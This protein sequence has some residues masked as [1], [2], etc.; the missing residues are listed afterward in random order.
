MIINK[1]NYSKEALAV[2]LCIAAICYTIATPIIII[3]LLLSFAAFTYYQFEKYKAENISQK[4]ATAA[5]LIGTSLLFAFLLPNAY[6]LPISMAIMAAAY[7]DITTVVSLL[8]FTCTM[9]LFAPH[10][11]ALAALSLTIGFAF[12][13]ILAQSYDIRNNEIDKYD[14]YRYLGITAFIG[15]A[16]I[17][18]AFIPLTLSFGSIAFTLLMIGGG[19]MMS[20]VSNLMNIRFFQGIPKEEQLNIKNDKPKCL[21]LLYKSETDVYESNPNA[22]PGE[23]E[24]TKTKERVLVFEG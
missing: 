24:I 16:T 14:L 18:S 6:L 8:I 9:L 7:D 5:I 13:T 11:Y 4:L 17:A 3:T 22:K 10:F 2:L 23:P 19:I 12:S 15:I 20:L 21:E 1:T